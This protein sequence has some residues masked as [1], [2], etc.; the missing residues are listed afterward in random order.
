MLTRSTGV[1]GGDEIVTMN[2]SNDQDGWACEV[3]ADDKHG[4]AR[5]GRF[6]RLI[7]RKMH[8]QKKTA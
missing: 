4:M 5:W 1:C 2:S 3:A 8:G 7:N 6:A